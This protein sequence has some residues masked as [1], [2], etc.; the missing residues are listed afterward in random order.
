MG[1]RCEPRL[2]GDL[3]LCFDSAMEGASGWYRSGQSRDLP[4]LALATGLNINTVV[5]AGSLWSDPV[6]RAGVESA[7]VEPLAEGESSQAP[8][9]EE[10]LNEIGELEELG[11][12]IGW[13]TNTRDPRPLR[14]L[15]R[16]GLDN[17]G[18][19]RDC[20]ARRS[21]STC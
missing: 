3:S 10:V 8:T 15:V 13:T 1:I 21:V 9:P 5:G 17:H 19:G 7:I 14:R 6:L 11:I 4:G 20:K 12:P 2:V 16:T 18:C